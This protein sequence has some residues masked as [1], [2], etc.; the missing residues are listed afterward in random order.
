MAMDLD[1]TQRLSMLWK[2]FH[3][4][5]LKNYPA[6]PSEEEK[7]TARKWYKEFAN[8]ITCESCKQDYNEMLQRTPPDVNSRDE[9]FKWTYDRHDELNRKLNKPYCPDYPSVQEAYRTGDFTLL[10]PRLTKIQKYFKE[11]G[12]SLSFKQ[13]T[14]LLLAGLIFVFILLRQ[15]LEFLGSFLF[16][17]S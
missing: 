3:L 11:F 8:L 14:L 6:E 13:R 5:P 9:L 10:Q 15:A 17:P 4:Y 1:S 7:A 2:P 16:C 12:S